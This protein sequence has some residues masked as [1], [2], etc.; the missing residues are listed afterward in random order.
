MRKSKIEM[1]QKSSKVHESQSEYHPLPQKRP[2]V[3]SGAHWWVQIS[4]QMDMWVDGWMDRYNEYFKLYCTLNFCWKTWNLFFILVSLIASFTCF[5]LWVGH[6]SLWFIIHK[7]QEGEWSRASPPSH[8][9]HPP[10]PGRHPPSPGRLL[11]Y[12]LM[13]LSRGSLHWKI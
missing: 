12:C 11:P 7:G 1:S 10:S 5:I 13:C 8:G 9:P 4:A 2:L 3:I 6:T